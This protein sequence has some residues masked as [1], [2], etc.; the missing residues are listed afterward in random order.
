MELLRHERIVTTEAKAKEL[1]PFAERVI[2]LGKRG[3]LH[4]RRQAHALL[5]D[6]KIVRRLFDDIAPRYQDR[7]GGYTRIT[8]LGPRVGDGAHMAQIELVEGPEPGPQ[9]ETTELSGKE[10]S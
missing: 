8:K 4:A 6:P 7:P 2:G 10:A 9:E 1:R 5:Q 3:D